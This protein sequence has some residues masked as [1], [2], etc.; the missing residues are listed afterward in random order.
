MP[1]TIFAVDSDIEKIVDYQFTLSP[2][3]NNGLYTLT[4]FRNPWSAYYVMSKVRPGPDLLITAFG[5]D[6]HAFM[7]GPMLVREVHKLGSRTK[8]IMGDD[9]SESIIHPILDKLKRDGIDVK[10]IP[11]YSVEFNLADLVKSL[12]GE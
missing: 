7:S 9:R 11:Y 12:I 4:T 2:K 6:D 5:F 1:K 3:L 10:Y 8:F